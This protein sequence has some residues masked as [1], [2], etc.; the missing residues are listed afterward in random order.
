[1]PEHRVDLCHDG[2]VTSPER[3]VHACQFGGARS[4][5]EP[6]LDNYALAYAQRRVWVFGSWWFGI[7]L[8]TSGAVHALTSL[9]MGSNPETG[10]LMAL[11]GLVISGVGWAVSAPKRFTRKQPKPAMDVPRAEQSIRINRGVVIVSNVVMAAGIAALAWM[12]KPDAAAEGVPVLAMLAVW[13]PMVGVLGLRART[14]LIERQ[15][16]YTTWLNANRPR[17]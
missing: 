2:P 16:R 10:A 13:A 4:A 14:L 7:I 6:T 8:A 5:P 15:P 12:M 11:L 1:M 3:L 17:T 9:L